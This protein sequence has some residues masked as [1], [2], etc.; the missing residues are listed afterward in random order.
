LINLIQA[1][2]QAFVELTTWGNMLWS[3][4]FQIIIV[5]VLLYNKI[6]Y[7][8]LFGFAALVVVVPLNAFFTNKYDKNFGKKLEMKDQR[9][10]ILNE[11]LNGIKVEKFYC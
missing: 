8:A 10:K 5:F 6:G 4:P 3:A 2:C 1:N 11:I 9:L 7:A